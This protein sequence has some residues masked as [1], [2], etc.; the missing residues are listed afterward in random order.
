M[1][2]YNHRGARRPGEPPELRGR[3]PDAARP[4]PRGPRWGGLIS[5]IALFVCA[6][7]WHVVAT[8]G[9]AIPAE[10]VVFGQRWAV[11][12]ALLPEAVRPAPQVAASSLQPAAPAP[13]PVPGAIRAEP[14]PPEHRPTVA[15]ALLA[16]GRDHVA[17]RVYAA[18]GSVSDRDALRGAGVDLV[19]R[20]LATVDFPLRTAL[21]RHRAREPQRYGLQVPPPVNSN[22][23]RDVLTPDNLQVF[24][25]AFAEEVPLDPVTGAEPAIWQGGDICLFSPSPSGRP[26]MVALVSDRVDDDGGALLLT[27]DPRDQVALEAH[28]IADYYL[29]GHFRLDAAALE[30]CRRRLELP[31]LSEDD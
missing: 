1:A 20:G 14:S 2:V 13:A 4:R 6:V 10:V 15:E 27:L 5:L 11:P 22:E 26:L 21:L 23:R 18:W 24:L 29:Q 7:L 30:R 8:G 31:S 9:L 25:Q 3:S 28:T 12:A 19:E 17:R 16:L